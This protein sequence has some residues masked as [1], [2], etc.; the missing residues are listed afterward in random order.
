MDIMAQWALED[1]SFK[2]VE[3]KKKESDLSCLGK[4]VSVNEA[5]GMSHSA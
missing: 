3:L 4:G 2:A 5:N 1:H